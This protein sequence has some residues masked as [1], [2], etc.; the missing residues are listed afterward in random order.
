ME[1]REQKRE[2]AKKA[3][4]YSIYSKKAARIQEARWNQERASTVTAP[5]VVPLK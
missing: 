2:S 4:E 3:R 1:K 5:P